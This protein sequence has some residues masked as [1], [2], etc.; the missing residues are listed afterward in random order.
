[1]A[2]GAVDSKDLPLNNSL[3]A[4][5]QDEI[6]RVIKN[7]LVKKPIELFNEPAEDEE[8]YETFY[9]ASSKD[10]K[11]GVHEDSTNRAKIAMLLRYHSTKPGDVQTSLDGHISRMMEDQKGIYYV[12]GQSKGGICEAAAKACGNRPPAFARTGR[13]RSPSMMVVIM[14]EQELRELP[15]G[16]GGLWEGV[17]HE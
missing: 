2:E 8:T 6:L 11:L 15:S 5:Q 3:E 16:G 13:E 7:N 14:A 4:L 17:P 12:T 1:M 9:E 10:L